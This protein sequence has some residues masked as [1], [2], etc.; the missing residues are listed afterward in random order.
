MQQT[1]DKTAEL[2]QLFNRI[3]PI[4]T[5][6]GGKTDTGTVPRTLTINVAIPRTEQVPALRVYM[7]SGLNVE[8]SPPDALIMGAAL[9]VQ[10]QRYDGETR[11][12][13]WQLV[14][15]NGEWKIG[16]TPLFD[17]Q[18]EACLDRT[19]RFYDPSSGQ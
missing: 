16:N 19:V 6:K 7:P 11:L 14:F 12:T 4:A 17:V 18:I 2:T 10:V 9:R 1:I 5:E 15:L 3:V 8:F 13:D